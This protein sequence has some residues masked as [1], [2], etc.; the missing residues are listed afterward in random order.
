MPSL[1]A[2]IAHP[3][4]ESYSFGGTVALAAAAA[5]DCHV[6]CATFGEGGERH[7]GGPPD[8]ESLAAAREAELARSCE[9]LGARPPAFWGL[10]DG[11]LALH[12]GEHERLARL[13]AD[14]RP[15]LV[16]ALGADGAYGHPDHLALYRWLL[17]ALEATPEPRPAVLF[18]AF[19][20]GLFI[21]QYTRCVASGI[22]GDPPLLSSD[23]IGTNE[24]HYEVPI[25][26]VKD[27]KLAALA[28]HRT[29]LPAA[30]PEAMFPPGIVAALLDVE[31]FVDA[32]GKRNPAV[33]SLLSRLQP[34][35]SG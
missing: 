2:V 1:L 10:P 4:D 14:L 19:P 12:R 16:L 11:E 28:A 32:G 35:T 27:Q 34:P 17:A 9:I 25:A 7:E 8:R 33:V 13:F 20:P 30:E 29:Q 18:A 22:M 3:D 31:R 21:P 23:A 26:A 15:D 6:H 24:A 5:W